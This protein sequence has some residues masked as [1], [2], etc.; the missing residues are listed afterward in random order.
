MTTLLLAVIAVLALAIGLAAGFLFARNQA[1]SKQAEARSD[2]SSIREEAEREAGRITESARREAELAAKEESLKVKAEAEEEARARRTE[3]ARYEERLDNRDG[4]LDR[5]DK[6]LENRNRNLDQREESLKQR[7]GNLEQHEAEQ[8][9][10]LEEI[11]GLSRADA[12][13]RLISEV[14]SELE[15]KVGRMIRDRTLEAEQ[16]AEEEAKH[17]LSTTM[18]RLASDHTSE[19]T[20]K[21]VALASDDMKGRVIGK[22]GRNIRAFEAATGVDVI[23]DD[24][25]ETVVLSCFDSVRREIARIS[26]ERLVKDGRIH[27]GRIEQIVAKAK[28]D[29]DKEMKNAGRQALDDAKITGGMDNELVGLLGALKYRT[30]YGQNVLA[31]SVEVANLCGM[32]GAELGADVKIC[33]RA[34][35]LHDVG[36][37]VDHEVEGTHAMIGGRY[38]KKSGEPDPVVRAISAHHHEI[39]METVEDVL[40]ATADAVSA[41]RP[42]ARQETTETYIERLRSLES[43][44][45]NHD[46]V[47]KAYA[48]QAGREVRVMVQ[49]QQIDDRIA[50]KLAWDISKQIENDLQ[51]PG[52]IKVTVI[53][54]SRVSEVAR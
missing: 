42:G 28:K 54:E 17:I 15:G 24:T 1:D 37:A 20:V 52:Q 46:G 23:I 38:A 4:A 32:M 30:S 45:T 19:S 40:V 18:E 49:P 12:E 5:R 6:E 25:P 22:E 16:R 13:A 33:R 2:A 50:A 51:Y 48:I 34:G 7:E 21:T 14:E 53:R 36:K 3:L 10:R 39:E 29:V 31:H 26:M 44:A 43:I 9:L 41:A 11:S 47:E 35:L 8:Q 27:P